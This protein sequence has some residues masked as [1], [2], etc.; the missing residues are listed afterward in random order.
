MIFRRI[1]DWIT[2]KYRVKMFPFR[3]G[4]RKLRCT[5]TIESLEDLRVL[6][7]IDAEEELA[8]LMKQEILNEITRTGE[9]L[10]VSTFEANNDI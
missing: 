3:T 5:W 4:R 7:S 9:R 6:H 1:I 8:E 2:G 10:P